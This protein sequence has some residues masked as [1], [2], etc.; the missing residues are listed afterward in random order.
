MRCSSFS[1]GELASS[2]TFWWRR[3]SEQSR[4]PRWTALPSPSPTTCTSIWR[5]FRDISRCRRH[6]CRTP[7]RLPSAPLTAPSRVSSGV[8]GH[9]HAAPAAAGGRLDDHRIADLL[10]DLRGFLVR[11]HVRPLSPEPPECRGARRSSWPSILSPMI[12]DVLGGGSDEG[13]AVGIKD[14]GELGVLRQEAVARMHRVRA[15][16]LAGG[17]DLVNVEIAVARGRR[18]DAHA[19]VGKRTCMASWSA[20]ECTATVLMPSSL[21]A[22]STRSAISP[23]LA[24][25]T[26]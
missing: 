8:V 20:V 23:R 14:I 26:F 6:R 1:T 5:G 15:G 11:G 25:R 17:N 22:R 9:L 3:C 4:S 7:R 19:L 16:D 21:Q 2:Q 18:A 10:G 24:M 12:S 13:D